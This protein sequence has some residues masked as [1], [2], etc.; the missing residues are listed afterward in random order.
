MPT[1]LRPRLA[2][3]PNGGLRLTTFNSKGAEVSID[4][5]IGH[6]LKIIHSILS[7]RLGSTMGNDGTPTQWNA[8]Q[9]KG[10]G[11]GRNQ[12]KGPSLPASI[13]LRP[14]QLLCGTCASAYFSSPGESCPHCN[15]KPVRLKVPR[16]SQVV[17][18]L[19]E[20]GL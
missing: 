19:E 12:E 13:D 1:D 6:E 11:W 4:M 14:G 15:G 7:A 8:D 16:R 20:L 18:T 2:L 17:P 5:P 10:N 9:F 3:S